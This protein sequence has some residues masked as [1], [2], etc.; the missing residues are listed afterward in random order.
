MTRHSRLAALSGGALL[1]GQTALVGSPPALAQSQAPQQYRYEQKIMADP[2][3]G[4]PVLKKRLAVARFDDSATV[5][6]SP[7]GVMDPATQKKHQNDDV[8]SLL[9]KD[10]AV[11]RNGFTERLVTALFATDRFIVV[12]RQD[13]HKILREQDFS[14]TGRISRSS[15]LVQ[16]ENLSA[17]YLV[18]GLVTFDHG[19]GQDTTS[20]SEVQLSIPIPGS[21]YR[22]TVGS[23]RATPAEP[24]ATEGTGSEATMG[25]RS[26][27]RDMQF[28]CPRKPGAAPKYALHLR[29]YDTSTSQVVSAVRVSADNQWCLVKAAVQ[30]MI[31]QMD[32][33]PWKTRVA[34]VD[35]ERVV[36][37][38]GRDV[39]MSFEYRAYHQLPADRTSEGARRA[40][41]PSELQIVEINELSSVAK[42]TSA[43]PAD[44]R[45]GDW[46]V[47]NATKGASR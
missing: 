47:F 36:L 14:K 17:Q 41:V 7:F 24:G 12:E 1:V 35:G 30:N 23:G 22:T 16:S 26:L 5:E 33:F 42:P 21:R 43:A 19:E 8:N 29:V 9:T 11:I 15:S 25:D 34:A 40:P 28:Q 6:D 10:L 27:L 46:V 18:T 45:V 2:A 37:D 13:I 38:G 39:N 32:K 4:A 20:D 3:E 31:V 44:I